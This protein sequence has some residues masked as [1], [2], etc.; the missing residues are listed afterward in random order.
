[1]SNRTKD[2][3]ENILLRDEW[4]NLRILFDEL[5]ELA[6]ID[7]IKDIQFAQLNRLIGEMYEFT[8]TAERQLEDAENLDNPTTEPILNG[9]INPLNQSLEEIPDRMYELR[10]QIANQREQAAIEYL[11][12][13]VEVG[14]STP[15]GIPGFVSRRYAKYKTKLRQIFW[16]DLYGY[17][18]T[19]RSICKVFDRSV[20]KDKI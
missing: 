13:H 9:I 15:R 6:T 17:D 10:R 18:E 20:Y 12:N 11:L 5:A 2:F 3:V 8:N 4:D 7:R 19:F 16:Q 1:M 14:E